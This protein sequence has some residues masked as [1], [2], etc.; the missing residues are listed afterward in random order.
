[1]LESNRN[2][3]QYIDFVDQMYKDCDYKE[4][5]GIYIVY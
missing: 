3:P 2:H 5:D 1:M 4:V